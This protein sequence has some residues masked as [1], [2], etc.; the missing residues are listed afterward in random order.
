VDR[1]TPVRDQVN[2]MDAQTYYTPFAELLTTNPPTAAD[3][4]MVEKLA[5]IGIVPGQALDWTTVDPAMQQALDDAIRPT[6]GKMLANRESLGETVNGWTFPLKTGTYGTDYLGRATVTVVGLGANRPEDTVYPTSTKDPDG[7]AYSGANDYVMHF[8]EG[9][10]PPADAFW[11][12]TM[13]DDKAC[14]VGNPLDRLALRAQKADHTR[15]GGYP[16][17]KRC[18]MATNQTNGSVTV[19]GDHMHGKHHAEILIMNR[20]ADGPGGEGNYYN[21]LGVVDEVPDEEFDARFRALDPETLK[22]EFGGDAIRF[23]GPRRFLADRL[24]G[25]AFDGGEPRMVGPIPMHLYGTFVV[26]DFDAFVS[27]KQTPYR[28]TV[29]RRTST[30]F[31]EAGTEVYELVSPTGSV[32]VMQ[33]ASLGVDPNNA[34]DKLPTLGERL[35]L[36]EGWTYRTRT[37]DEELVMRVTFDD[38]P[39]NTIVLDEFE[40]NYQH[41]PNP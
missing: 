41:L 35:A 37:L 17:E 4:P 32:Y 22:E 1:T 27:G 39:P 26:P 31:F 10:L 20:N 14:F 11:S 2:R 5:T 19:S 8:E 28:E 25:V 34:V 40:N 23:N 15:T 36:P 6:Q 3:A 18:T 24:T 21:S 9:Q 13:Y 30:W 7:N 38:D 29:S 16:R 33:S 12:L